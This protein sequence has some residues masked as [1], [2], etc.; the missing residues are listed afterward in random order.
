MRSNL[1]KNYFNLFENQFSID[2]AITPILSQ[3]LEMNQLFNLL[4]PLPKS[5]ILDYGS[6]TGRLSLFFLSNGFNVVAYDISFNS[7]KNLRTA[8]SKFKNSNWGKLKTFTTL[9]L[10][11]K[12]KY[13]VGSDVLHHIS[14]KQEL[15]MMYK[16]LA[17]NGKLVFSEPNPYNISWYLFY[18]IRRIPWS[19]ESKIMNCTRN[20]LFQE[21][22][23]ISFKNIQFTPH[24]LLPTR[25]L[26][27]FP[28]L[29]SF[30]ALILPKLF[31]LS[32]LS[33]RTIV[34]AQK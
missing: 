26:N 16:H 21:L 25:L 10:H 12:T 4:N 17:F 30:N 23:S 15:P 33:Y 7:L 6:G 5:T 8:Y 22:K 32:L 18:F 24:G 20:N 19:I 1:Q 3:R 13:I 9:P 34:S 27:S 14:L 11:L 2:Q 29:C 28:K 31:P